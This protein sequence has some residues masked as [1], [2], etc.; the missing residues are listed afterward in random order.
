MSGWKYRV[1]LIK[2]LHLQFKSVAIVLE[3]ENSSYTCESFIKFTL[4]HFFT[5]KHGT[6]YMNGIKSESDLYEIVHPS[7]DLVFYVCSLEQNAEKVYQ[8]EGNPCGLVSYGWS[9]DLCS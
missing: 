2:L 5:G 3:S 7:L 8:I 9:N 6:S 1:N 4:G